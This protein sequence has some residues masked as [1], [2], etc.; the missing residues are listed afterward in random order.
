MPVA[1][2]IVLRQ[3]LFDSMLFDRMCFVLALVGSNMASGIKFELLTI[4]GTMG[5]GKPEPVG[6]GGV[7]WDSQGNRL[8]EFAA[9]VGIGNSNEAEFSAN[10]MADKIEREGLSMTGKCGGV[11]LEQ[12]QWSDLLVLVQLDVSASHGKSLISD[13][14]ISKK[15]LSVSTTRHLHFVSY[16]EGSLCKYVLKSCP[17]HYVLTSINPNFTWFEYFANNFDGD[18]P[19][20]NF[21]YFN[22]SCDG[23]LRIGDGYKGLDYRICDSKSGDSWV[24][25]SEV[26]VHS[27]GSNIW[28]NASSREPYASQNFPSA[29]KL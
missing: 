21:R 4:F 22:D 7:I 13:P 11:A 28:R 29:V 15:H 19:P 16:K 1:F 2:V 5:K 17:L 24:R 20:D 3:G 14:K 8:A 23:I 9:S 25:K 26:K 18:Y 10:Q 27:L 12:C 6:I